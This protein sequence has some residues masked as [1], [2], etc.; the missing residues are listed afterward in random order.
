MVIGHDTHCLVLLHCLQLCPIFNSDNLLLLYHFQNIIRGFDIE[1]VL[2][3][4][5]RKNGAVLEEQFNP[6][7]RVDSRRLNRLE[8]H[9]RPSTQHLEIISYSSR[10]P[11]CGVSNYFLLIEIALSQKLHDQFIVVTIASEDV[12]IFYQP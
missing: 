10:R 3:I 4:F 2:V 7:V 8:K 9:R 5:R 12:I 6:F 11:Y 1:L